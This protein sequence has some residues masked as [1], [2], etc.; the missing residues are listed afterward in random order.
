MKPE[1]FILDIETKPML[2]WVWD[3][4]DQNI[5]LNQIKEDSCIIAWAAKRLGDPESKVVYYDQRNAKN[6]LDDREIVGKLWG[7]LD[8]ADFIITQNGKSFDGPRVN[9]RFLAHGMQPPSP[10]R[11]LDTY[12]I[13]KR[14]AKFSSHKLEYMTEKLNKKYKKL[15]HKNFPGFDLWKECMAG[16]KKAWDEMKTY[17]IHDVLSTEELYKTLQ[18]WDSLT[19]FNSFNSETAHQCTCG[20]KQF[21]MR[22]Y[23]HTNTGKFQR[24]ICASCGKWGASKVNLLT[25]E[26]RKALNKSAGSH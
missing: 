12:L 5:S 23:T 8:K 14:V 15:L 6:I 3:L 20:S 18:P 16:N 24:F 2:A 22:G 7:L 17:N 26:K 13:S 25:L 4:K 10:Y 11:H 21:T 9:A 19:D 1:I